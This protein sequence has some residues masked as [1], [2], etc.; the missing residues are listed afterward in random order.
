M[1]PETRYART[2]DGTHVAYQV[3]G[4]G[5]VDILVQR[6]WFSNLD[7]EW[8]EPVL[9]GIY[10]RL[11]SV[12][13]VIRID[14]R[15]SGLSDRF[16]PSLLPTI[17]DRIDDMR[18]VMDA[19]HTER[20]VLLGLGHASALFAVFAAMHPER[21]HALVMFSPPNSIV[22]RPEEPEKS[23][24][25]ASIPA[26]WAT[27]AYAEEFVEAGAPSRRDD[28]SLIAWWQEEQ[29]LSASPEDAVALVRLANET[30]VDDV[31]PAIR[32][33]TLIVWRAGSWAAPTARHIVGRISTVEACELPGVDAFLL[34]GDWQRA[35]ASIE[36]FILG[37]TQPVH[38]SDR[39]LST[40]MFTDV[41]GSTELATE[42]GDRA[43][44]EL[45]E[46]HHAVVRT[47]LARHRGREID[48]AGDGFFATF[49]GPGRAIRCA[50]AIRDAVRA[51]DLR[52]RIGLHA[53]E[54]ER[55]GNGLRGV[56]V[57]IGARIGAA[58]KPDE[59]LV[60]STV[61]DLVAGSGIVF[62]DA[63]RH[64][65]KGV[66]DPWQLYRV[67]STNPDPVAGNSV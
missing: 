32:V 35:V 17:E 14:R 37:V 62:E 23:A 26:V 36:Q 56:A 65:L 18:A 11:G 59:V 25:E 15:G 52:L 48:T 2:T 66:P 38:E 19:L 30:N 13:R 27:H 53:G 31:L 12:G 9:A 1:T 57:H 63:G 55:V 29:R 50:A 4:D 64:D 42:L 3:H 10:R 6:G 60:S 43:W 44:R 21:T 47:E 33:P 5:P 61:R 46:R 7:H 49:D 16:D 39:V 24:Y 20:L 45:L 54:C 8:E 58:A 41:V 51:L 28:Q 40:L 22:Y 67:A 34:A